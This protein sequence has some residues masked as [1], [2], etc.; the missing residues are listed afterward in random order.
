L[1]GDTGRRIGDVVVEDLGDIV[2][3]GSGWFDREQ[4]IGSYGW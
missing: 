3:V 1:L 2:G 4:G